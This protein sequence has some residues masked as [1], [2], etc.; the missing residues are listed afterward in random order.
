[1]SSWPSSRTR[2]RS[3]CG[4]DAPLIPWPRLA[5]SGRLALAELAAGRTS[6]ILVRDVSSRFHRWNQFDRK[7][8][9]G[10]AKLR[11][12]TNVSIAAPPVPATAACAHQYSI[13]VPG[14]GY[15]SRLR[16]LLRCGGAVVHV[17]HASSEF[18][19]PLLRHREHLYLLD[20]REPVRG[21]GVPL[22]A[23]D[24]LRSP[25]VAYLRASERLSA[26][27]PF[28]VSASGAP[29]SAAAA[30]LPPCRPSAAS[31]RR[32]S[33]GSGVCQN[34][35]QLRERAGLPAHA[36]CHVCRAVRAW[37]NLERCASAER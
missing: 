35:A 18:F 37:T 27:L 21:L 36:A 17:V 29:R 26:S 19:M 13:N 11:A 31:A 33:G 22:M 7:Q 32:G 1:M 6:E 30:S 12:Q 10:F 2:G 14:F 28:L 3:S 34:L 9:P 4:H 23:S 5:R 8:A 24:C 20:G 15:S 16:A 25:L